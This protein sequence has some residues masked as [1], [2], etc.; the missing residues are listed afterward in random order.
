MGTSG[1]QPG[2]RQTVV[3]VTLALLAVL[4]VAVALN[5]L[6]GT[7][8]TTE[9]AVPRLDTRPVSPQVTREPEPAAG[10]PTGALLSAPPQPEAASAPSSRATEFAAATATLRGDDAPSSD[11]HEAPIEELAARAV[12]AVVLV[13]TPQGRGTAFFIAPDTL[14]TNVHVVGRNP[15]V[16]IRRTDGRSASARVTAASDAV[17]LAVLKV[18]PADVSTVVLPLG[19]ALT[20][21]VGQDV[22][23]IGSALGTLQSTVTRG[24]V[25][26]VRR[27][28]QV[29]LVQT[30]A[31]VN[32]GNSGGPLLTRRGQVV[33][34]TTLGYAD[35][36]GLNFAVAADHAEGLVGGRPLV[37]P[38]AA[39]TSRAA[40]VT[41]VI[42][43]ALPSET[44]RV[45]N[46]GARAYEATVA[47][48]AREGDRIDDV[49]ERYRASCR[50]GAPAAR[51]SRAWFAVLHTPL[52]QGSSAPGCAEW[53]DDV[54]VR[55]QAVDRAMREA[56]ELARRADVY[57]GTRRD[58]RLR[59][60][61]DFDG[62]DR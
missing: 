41:G 39:D 10:N 28:G 27:T 52:L 40:D 56:E 43:P 21:R 36:Q 45:R 20:V 18:A 51:G 46:E 24:I 37:L 32:P 61:L 6:P 1:Q 59:Y 42:S 47:R 31:A 26:A 57:P 3:A 11:D 8:A 62:W 55:A 25:S 14:L 35:R 29:L 44:D 19:S 22:V 48:L 5:G 23:A 49:W 13:D 16:T 9:E 53:L 2:A 15:Q 34:I 38:P 60:R 17:D 50:A 7:P 4:G 30:D 58:H 54:R 33:G 12:H